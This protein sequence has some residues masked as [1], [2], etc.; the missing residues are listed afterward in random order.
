MFRDSYC[1]KEINFFGESHHDLLAVTFRIPY[2]KILQNDST[3]VRLPPVL[4]TPLSIM[5]Q[6]FCV[7]G[8]I[9]QDLLDSVLSAVED[10][11]KEGISP[12]QNVF[13][14]IKTPWSRN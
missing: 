12:Y 6:N 9:E 11:D 7:Q 4:S 1:S 8:L 13:H 2:S 3:T 5:K 14:L 10:S